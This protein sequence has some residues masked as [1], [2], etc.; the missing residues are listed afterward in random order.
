[1]APQKLLITLLYIVLLHQGYSKYQ[2]SQKSHL[3]HEDFF[4]NCYLLAPQTPSSDYTKAA[5][6]DC[7]SNYTASLPNG[8]HCPVNTTLWDP[9]KFNCTEVVTTGG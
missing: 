8:S 9:I 2:P 5:Y 3:Y 4:Y 1:M 7:T 6:C